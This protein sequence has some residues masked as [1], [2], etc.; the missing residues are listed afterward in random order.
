VTAA[1]PFR[2]VP[3]RLRFGHRQRRT[4]LLGLPP[5]GDLRAI[6]DVN[7]RRIELPAE[8]LLMSAKLAKSLGVAPGNTVS[9][10]VL[11]GERRVTEVP[12]AGLVDDLIGVSVYL[13]LDNL[14]RLLREEGA[15]SGAFLDVD[16]AQRTALY[17][18]L[19]RLPA[20]RGV[21][22]KEA[23][24]AG[25]RDVIARSLIVQT[26]MN[27]V[28]AC[29]IASGVVYN[30]V[31]IALSERARELAS[32]RVLGFTRREVAVMLLGEQALLTAAAIPLGFL[33]GYGICAAVSAA[34]NAQQETFR[35]P[36]VL[37]TQTFAFAFVVVALAAMLSGLMVWN[38][39]RRL[40]LVAVLKTRE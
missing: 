23:M 4:G 35:L 24:L 16:E 27:I 8:G 26:T 30:S 32:L 9:V 33:I 20:V 31:R 21:S 13:S 22:V 5:A 28:F 3:V 25:F 36:L 10:E 40:D 12:V 2:Y 37:T 17:A 11:E 39:L 14:N 18:A 1:E 29:V 19:K 38:R 7:Y 34:L 15:L 6:V